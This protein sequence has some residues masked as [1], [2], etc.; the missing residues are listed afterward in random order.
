MVLTRCPCPNPLDPV[1]VTLPG[2]RDFAG[3]TEIKSFMETLFWTIWVGFD[4]EGCDDGGR[5]WN[6]M[7]P[8]AKERAVF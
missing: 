2:K 1:T 7:R 3:V 4:E 5:G 6:G 8:G